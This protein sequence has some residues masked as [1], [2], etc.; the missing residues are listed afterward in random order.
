LGKWG[1]DQSFQDV[2][3]DLIISSGVLV[4]ERSGVFSFGHLTFQE[5]LAGEYLAY[6][7]TP[8]QVAAK[9]GDDWWREPLNFY[10]CIKGD[11]T[12]LA[13]CLIYL[14]EFSGSSKQLAEMLTYAP[15]TSPGIM[16][17]FGTDSV[18][19]DEDLDFD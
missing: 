6:S 13:E 14:G 8:R 16:E 19:E 5:H 2:L 10:A 3:N 9:Y 7:C 17:A 12:E 11:L 4:E 1:Y 18:E 15:Y